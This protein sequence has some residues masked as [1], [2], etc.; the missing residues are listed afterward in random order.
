MS[1]HLAVTPAEALLDVPRDIVVT[2]AA[3][4]ALV[5]VRATT[6]RPGGPWSAQA[7]FLA[8]ATGT[9]RL[10]REPPAFGD[11]GRVDAMAL[12]T[13]QRPLPGSPERLVAGDVSAPVVTELEAWDES[14]AE[15]RTSARLVQQ[16][17]GPGVRRVEVR[18]PGHPA[19]GDGSSSTEGTTQP[20]GTLFVP[21]GPGPHPTVVVL[22]GSGGGVQEQRGALYA[23]RGIQAFA[24]GYFRV[25]GR[26]DFITRTPLE[27]FE[28][29]LRWVHRELDPRSGVVVVSGQSRGGEL[30]LLL[31]ATYPELV[32]GVVAYVPGAHVHGAQGA[33]DPAEGWDS[34][35]WTLGGEPLDHLWDHNPGVTWQPWT[36]G[37]PP[38]RY[39]DVYLDGLRDRTFAATSR[40]PVEQIVGPVLCVSGMDDALWPSSLYSRQV[41]AALRAAGHPHETLHL[42]YPDAGHSIA[43]PH[44]PVAQGPSYH[45]VSGVEISSGGT[46]AGGAFADADSFARVCAFVERA[47][48]RPDQT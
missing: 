48:A 2:G 16:Q 38:D 36:G 39:R 24:L 20:V 29:A 40:I 17:I 3:P 23:S 4:G 31:G 28:S 8:D 9:V 47:T 12:L 35:T 22:S 13:S 21:A 43:L 19:S 34:P 6:E 30:A 42:D 1:L 18:A 33:A 26:S 32:G 25:P 45:P 15:D 44:L 14:A 41:V 37:P 7:T 46:P 27:Y 10:D 11:Y 5:T